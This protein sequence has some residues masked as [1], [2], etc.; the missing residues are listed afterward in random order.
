[1]ASRRSLFWS[2]QSFR[3]SDYE[4]KAKSKDGFGEDW[5]IGLEDVA[6]YYSRVEDI[7]QVYGKPEGLPQYPDGNFV[8]DESPWPTSMLR[9]AEAGK[10]MGLRARS[11]CC[12]RMRLQRA[13]WRRWRMPSSATLR[14]IR[15]PG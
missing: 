7:F 12:C 13:S 2:R 4:F 14:W 5:P 10:K 11:T 3:L 15:T 9:F 1:M 8:I 6:P